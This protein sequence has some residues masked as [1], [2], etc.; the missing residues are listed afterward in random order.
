KEFAADFSATYGEYNRV[1]LTGGIEGSLGD[2]TVARLYVSHDRHDG[3]QKDLGTGK[4]LRDLD[5][6]GGLLT[7]VTDWSDRF[8]TTLRA[9]YV[10]LESDGPTYD[11][12]VGS[13]GAFANAIGATVEDPD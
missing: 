3:D 9:D 12:I 11:Y 1:R 5:S 2:R 7:V 8:S 10:K 4:K 6:N 13:A